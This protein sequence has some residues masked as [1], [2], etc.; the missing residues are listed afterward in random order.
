M[1]DLAADS[2]RWLGE[3]FEAPLVSTGDRDDA[4][5]S[6]GDFLESD[7]L[8]ELLYNQPDLPASTDARTCAAF[9]IGRYAY[10]LAVPLAA[11]HLRAGLTTDIGS[12]ALSI[13]FAEIVLD[14]GDHS[15]E[16]MVP[17]LLFSGAFSYCADIGELRL[18]LERHLAPLI[19]RLH[20]ETRLSPGAQWRLA[21]DSLAFAFLGV[22][23]KLGDVAT[24]RE[25]V[26]ALLK[27]PAS[28]FTNP[29]LHFLSIDAPGLSEPRTCVARGGCCRYYKVEGGSLCSNC[30]LETDENQRT[31]MSAEI[32]AELAGHHD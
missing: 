28:P 23:E 30:V 20:A 17:H 32:A 16:L 18:E 15:H 12:K 21:G 25:T 27:H 24:A 26:T 14:H 6:Y 1:Q 5:S 13:G 9:F 4:F 8:R 3:N 10:F 29:Q 31:R 7:A 2:I 19:D 11:L 22:G